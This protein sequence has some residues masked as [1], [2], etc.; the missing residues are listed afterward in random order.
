MEV[1]FYNMIERADWMPVIKIKA[2]DHQKKKKTIK[3]TGIQ[4]LN[5]KNLFE[6]IVSKIYITF[7]TQ[8]SSYR[9][10]N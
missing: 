9:Q 10:S 8:W 6:R 1:T 3:K 4:S 5:R 7:K 2:I